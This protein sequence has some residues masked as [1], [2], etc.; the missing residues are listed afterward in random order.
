[1]ER[2]YKKMTTLEL[3]QELARE[4]SLP[5]DEYALLLNNYDGLTPT[6]R[7]LTPELVEVTRNVTEHDPKTL[8]AAMFQVSEA[9]K[10]YFFFD[11]HNIQIAFGD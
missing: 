2:Y 5:C 4:Y 3:S 6:E 8:A 1:M 11:H 7:E 10:L 9:V